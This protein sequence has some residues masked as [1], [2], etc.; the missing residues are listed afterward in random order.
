MRST[1]LAWRLFPCNSLFPPRSRRSIY[2]SLEPSWNFG[3]MENTPSICISTRIVPSR[4]S[5]FCFTIL[6]GLSRATE[7][8]LARF[9]VS[10]KW[11]RPL[12]EDLSSCDRHRSTPHTRGKNLRYVWAYT[13]SKSTLTVRVRE[14]KPARMTGN[15]LFQF[16]RQLL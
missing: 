15:V 6:R 16:I 11:L 3:I 12:A 2:V 5:S 7:T 13:P 8:F 1:R 9:P 14:K 4:L 10:V